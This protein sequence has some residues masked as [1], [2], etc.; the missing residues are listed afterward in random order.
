MN[1]YYYPHE[2]YHKEENRINSHRIASA[3]LFT[4]THIHT[5]HTHMRACI[6]IDGKGRNKHVHRTY[7]CSKQHAFV[8]EF[9]QN[10]SF[11]YNVHT[12]RWEM[13][14]IH[15]LWWYRIIVHFLLLLERT[16]FYFFE[17]LQ[18]ERK[19]KKRKLRK[20]SNHQLICSRC[21][22]CALSKLL[23]EI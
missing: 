18:S 21:K 19:K 1:V 20:F 4:W 17:A 5:L 12:S 15:T 8:L 13:V 6:D 22:L 14:H 11:A 16:Q 23:D 2:M 7:W 9:W 10:F 3:N